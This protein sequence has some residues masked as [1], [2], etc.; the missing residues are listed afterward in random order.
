MNLIYQWFDTQERER[1]RWSGCVGQLLNSVVHV[2]FLSGVIH[3]CLITVACIHSIIDY[4]LY[5]C[6]S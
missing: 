5:T 3:G 2:L 1:E 4:F 6:V